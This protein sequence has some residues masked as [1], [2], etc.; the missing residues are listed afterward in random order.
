VPRRLVLAI[1]TDTVRYRSSEGWRHY[2]PIG[3]IRRF[4]ATQPNGRQR[5]WPQQRLPGASG[6]SIMVQSHPNASRFP[7]DDIRR[8]GMEHPFRCCS[9]ARTDPVAITGAL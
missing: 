9:L 4:G 6:A 2:R 8:V 1:A 3:V 5:L 7:A